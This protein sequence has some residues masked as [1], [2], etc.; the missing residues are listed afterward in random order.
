MAKVLTQATVACPDGLSTCLP[1]N[2]S[3][4]YGR[5]MN[6]GKRLAGGLGLARRMEMDDF[7]PRALES[8]PR[9]HLT[10]HQRHCPPDGR[11]CPEGT[12]SGR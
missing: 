4:G 3:P 8:C 1:Q 9:A 5:V 12:L 11:T 6:W 2:S 10:G 7:V